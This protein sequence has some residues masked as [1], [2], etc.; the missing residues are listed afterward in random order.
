MVPFG[1]VFTEVAVLLM[2]A[3]A[4]GALAVSLRQPL[5]VAFIAV[6]GRLRD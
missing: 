1:D 4:L 5:I 6:R 3:A 2:M